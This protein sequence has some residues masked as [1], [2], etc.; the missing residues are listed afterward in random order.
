MTTK[1]QMDLDEVKRDLAAFVRELDGDG[2]TVTAMMNLTRLK[3]TVADL[4]IQACRPDACERVKR[5]T[6]ELAAM[7]AER[8]VAIA[9]VGKDGRRI[10]ELEAVEER[11]LAELAALKAANEWH[12]VSEPP[13]NS[14]DVWCHGKIDERGYYANGRWMYYMDDGQPMEFTIFPPTHWCELPKYTEGK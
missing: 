2:N 12:P 7:T 14:R 10:A 13:N 6:A 4:R 8:N 9:K 11:L 3:A 1:D 5:L